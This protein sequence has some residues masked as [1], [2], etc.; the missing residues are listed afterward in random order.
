MSSDAVS[1]DGVWRWDG[2]RWI[3]N[4]PPPPP[5]PSPQ[6]TTV[7]APGARP[8]AATAGRLPVAA[9]LLGALGILMIAAQVVGDT[10]RAFGDHSSFDTPWYFTTW[11]IVA[12]LVVGA[13]ALVLA[14]VA[15]LRRTGVAA[16]LVLGIAA[17]VFAQGFL[18]VYYRVVVS[19][20][21]YGAPL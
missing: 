17:V 4:S 10:L 12:L 2:Q 11:Y 3:P 18:D 19:H 5:P 7:P 13:C 20:F 6:T 21:G 16:A 15:V 14:T 1:A 9:L 8:A